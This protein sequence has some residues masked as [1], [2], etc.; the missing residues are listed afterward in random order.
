MDQV[1]VGI[2]GAGY[3]AGVHAGILANDERVA[4]TAIH[5][6]VEE[7]ARKLAGKHGMSSVRSPGEVID[8]CDAIYITTPNTKHVALALAAAGQNKHVFGKKPLAKI[9]AEAEGGGEKANQGGG[10]FQV[11]HNRRFPPFY[12][13]LKKMLS[14][15]PPPHSAHVKMNRGELL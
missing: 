9:V 1:K 12:P 2:V 10:F 11:G 8:R 15:P 5:D 14:K 7:S 4:L 3:I 6:V 13:N